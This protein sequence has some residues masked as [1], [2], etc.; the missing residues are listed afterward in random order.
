MNFAA[1]MYKKYFIMRYVLTFY[2]IFVANKA[3]YEKISIS[4]YCSFGLQFHA[5]AGT[6]IMDSRQ[7]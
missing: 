3:K 1:Q 5:F 2:C 4:H 7:R 6:V